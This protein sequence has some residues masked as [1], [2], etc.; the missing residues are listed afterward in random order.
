MSADRKPIVDA[1]RNGIIE[2]EVSP[3]KAKL[4]K[5]KK[6]HLVFSLKFEGKT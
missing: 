1:N 2:N 6:L 4:N 3:S 5:L